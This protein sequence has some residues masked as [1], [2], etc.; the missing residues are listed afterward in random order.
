MQ[1]LR[2]QGACRVEA[3]KPRRHLPPSALCLPT[4]PMPACSCQ[5]W[6]RRGQPMPA[7]SVPRHQLGQ[8]SRRRRRQTQL[9]HRTRGKSS[10]C[11]SSRQR[12][13]WIPA[14]SPQSPSARQAWKMLLMAAHGAPCKQSEESRS[15]AM[16]AVAHAPQ[17]RH[18]RLIRA[19]LSPFLCLTELPHLKGMLAWASA[20]SAARVCTSGVARPAQAATERE[21]MWTCPVA[22]ALPTAMVVLMCTPTNLQVT[23]LSGKHPAG[24]GV[25]ALQRRGVRG[26]GRGRWCCVFQ[27]GELGVKYVGSA[28]GTVVEAE[29]RIGPVAVRGSRFREGETA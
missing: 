26:V 7:N 27:E 14:P 5:P 20:S 11:S 2:S 22:T 29:A 19:S 3:A 9:L 6:P 15:A 16:P 8:P 10:G 4:F 17:T 28:Q 21:G 1:K 25:E 24:P 18:I 23:H 13:W 12:R